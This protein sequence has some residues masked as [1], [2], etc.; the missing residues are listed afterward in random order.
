MNDSLIYKH[1]LDAILNNAPV[2]I[3]LKDREGRYTKVNKHFET[4]FGVRNEDL[5]GMLPVDMPYHKLGAVARENDLSV[6]NSGK[7]EWSEESAELV[8]ESESHT[9]SAV[10]FPILDDDGDVEGLGVISTDIS[11]E[12]ADKEKL[13]ASEQRFSKLNWSNPVQQC[14]HRL[15]KEYCSKIHVYE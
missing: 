6:L 15:N 11:P 12:V 8:G 10:R 5:V 2:E 3:L 1:Q 7:T 13:L 4:A 9:W 14:Y